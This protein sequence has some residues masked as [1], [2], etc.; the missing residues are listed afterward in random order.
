MEEQLIELIKKIMKKNLP[1][2]ASTGIAS[3]IDESKRIC[4]IKVNDDITLFNCR[5]NAIIDSYESNILIVPKDGSQ[6]AYFLVENQDTNAIVIGYTEID[7]VIVKIGSLSLS[8]EAESVK[9]DGGDSGKISIFNKSQ[10]LSKLLS[11]LIDEITKLT[12]TT[13]AGPSGTPINTAQFTTIKQKLT[14]LM[15]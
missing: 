6:V 1:V 5:L 3:N 13:S 9:V 4:D 14:Q 2:M 8:I 15:E 7:K 11:E 12:V 10:N